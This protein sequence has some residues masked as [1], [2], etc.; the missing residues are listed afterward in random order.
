[1]RDDN[2]NLLLALILSGLVLFGR[3]YFVTPRAG[4]QQRTG[5]S[6][7][8]RAARENYRSRND[9]AGQPP[10]PS[11]A[12]GSD[13]AV[14]GRLRRLRPPVAVET[15]RSALA[16]Q[17]RACGSTRR[18]L[19][20]TRSRCGGR[21]ADEAL[22]TTGNGGFPRS[23]HRAVLASAARRTPT[24]PSRLVVRAGPTAETCGR[25]TATR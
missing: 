3:Q 6:S 7:R 25:R 11:Q 15:R 9:R 20:G 17:P 13:P 12:G 16:A 10:S 21:I 23:A 22:R 14:P 5:V 24:T 2:K 4:E 19:F 18:A 8:P 1:M